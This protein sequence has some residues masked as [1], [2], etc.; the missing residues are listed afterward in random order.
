MMRFRL[1]TLIDTLVSVVQFNRIVNHSQEW[2]G[3]WDG[4]AVLR[5]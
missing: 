3:E 4:K 2:I 1:R 5:L